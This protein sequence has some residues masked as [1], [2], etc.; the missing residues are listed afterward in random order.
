M[1]VLALQESKR[2]EITLND[3]D[4]D[5]FKAL[6]ESIHAVRGVYDQV[7]IPARKGV[8]DLVARIHDKLN[9]IE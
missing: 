5:A 7:T 1:A 9:G 6:I 3:E 8:H 4:V 2:L